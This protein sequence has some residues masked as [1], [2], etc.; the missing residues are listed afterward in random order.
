MSRSERRT[1]AFRRVPRDGMQGRR[2]HLLNHQY[3]N[4][5]RWSVMMHL[6]RITVK[7]ALALIG[8][9]GL[10]PTT[11]ARIMTWNDEQTE[12]SSLEEVNVLDRYLPSLGV[13][14]SKTRAA[15]EISPCKKAEQL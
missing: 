3:R 12:I 6:C 2:Q 11:H 10:S 15:V 8:I 4:G 13:H 7:L 5:Y 9:Y 14:T 1:A